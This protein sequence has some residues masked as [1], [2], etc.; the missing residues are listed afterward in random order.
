MY[1]AQ[2]QAEV[3][4]AKQQGAQ[5]QPAVP[6]V[7]AER[8]PQPEP[9]QEPQQESQQQSGPAIPSAPALQAEAPAEEPKSEVTVNAA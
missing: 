1:F 6:T 4:A 7:Q 8:Q 5:P 2:K 9:Q 3:E